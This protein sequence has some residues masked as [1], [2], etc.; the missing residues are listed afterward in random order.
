MPLQGETAAA[1][2]GHPAILTVMCPF[3]TLSDSIPRIFP[4]L[5]R[6]AMLQAS[7]RRHLLSQAKFL[8]LGTKSNSCQP[9]P[10]TDQMLGVGP[11]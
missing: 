3:S 2:R 11:M 8:R 10:W 4:L 7:R 5:D 9:W 1:Q 6:P